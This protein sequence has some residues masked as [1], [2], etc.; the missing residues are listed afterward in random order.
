MDRM[1]GPTGIALVGAVFV[2]LILLMSV[3]VAAQPSIM[4]GTLGG[5]GN[6]EPGYTPYQHDSDRGQLKLPGGTICFPWASREVPMGGP[7]HPEVMPRARPTREAISLTGSQPEEQVQD[8][9]AMNTVKQRDIVYEESQN[10]DPKAQGLV[11][12]MG[13]S[14][15]GKGQGK[16][17]WPEGADDLEEFVD[18]AVN[19]GMERNNRID[20]KGG[21]GHPG[22]KRLGNYM[23]IDVKGVSVSAINTVEGG[24]AVATSN[25]IIKPVQLIVCPSEVEEKLK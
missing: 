1:I 14:V 17:E 10:G 25:I 15:R 4:S 22:Q 3:S 16:R 9:K 18:N 24:S 21:D 6:F 23:N 11:N 8:L 7:L 5:I 20:G 13:V 2:C 12:S 19:S